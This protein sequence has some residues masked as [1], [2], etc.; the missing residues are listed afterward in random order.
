VPRLSIHLLGSFQ[1][2]LDGEPVTGFESDK[3]RALLAYLAVE[4]GGP[5]RREK[6]A[7]LCWPELP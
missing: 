6:L 3:V 1:V 2:N 5:H 4:T 7:G